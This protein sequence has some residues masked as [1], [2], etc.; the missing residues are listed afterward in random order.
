MGAN[1][2]QVHLAA[3]SAS[4]ASCYQNADANLSGELAWRTCVVRMVIRSAKN[5]KYHLAEANVNLKAL[6]KSAHSTYRFARNE[7][8]N[9]SSIGVSRVAEE[10]T[11]C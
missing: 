7:P 8:K 4:L 1:R 9:Y 5:T 2:L 11:R 3:P 10:A 6:L